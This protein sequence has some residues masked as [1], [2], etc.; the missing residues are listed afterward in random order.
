MDENK[1]VTVTEFWNKL[2]KESLNNLSFLVRSEISKEDR[3]F[4]SLMCNLKPT[5]VLIEDIN[6]NVDETITH[7]YIR[8]YICP[9]SS[10]RPQNVYI[11]MRGG[12][13]HAFWGYIFNVPEIAA[14]N[15]LSEKT[16][17]RF[18]KRF[19]EIVLLRYLPFQVDLQKNFRLEIGDYIMPT[20]W[21]YSA[22]LI[23]KHLIRLGSLGAYLNLKLYSAF[24]WLDGNID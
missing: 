18:L 23:Y 12:L 20:D 15:E 19:Y 14:W 17:S 5:T 9:I 11:S 16:Q 24:N 1:K 6:E 21:G 8:K 3:N 22:A 4:L 7:A 13:L 10:N 2:C